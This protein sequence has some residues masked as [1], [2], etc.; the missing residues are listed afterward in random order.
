MWYQK[1]L[2]KNSKGGFKVIGCADS[3]SKF[4]S[5]RW[6]SISAIKLYTIYYM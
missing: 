1:L 4:K 6:K 3:A 2:V 5:G